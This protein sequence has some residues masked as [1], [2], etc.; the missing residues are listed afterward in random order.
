MKSTENLISMNIGGSV[1]VGKTER[2]IDEAF[3][4]WKERRCLCVKKRRGLG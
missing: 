4:Y 2:R 1:L 3:A